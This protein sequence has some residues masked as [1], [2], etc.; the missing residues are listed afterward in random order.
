MKFIASNVY[1]DTLVDKHNRVKQ[2]YTSLDIEHYQ[3]PAVSS[4]ILMAKKRMF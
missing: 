2:S 3:C 1:T 4:V